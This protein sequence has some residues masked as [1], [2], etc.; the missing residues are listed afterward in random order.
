MGCWGSAME[1]R[2][3][4]TELL[5]TATQQE[6]RVRA[7]LARHATTRHGARNDSSR[8]ATPL[9]LNRVPMSVH[10][11][12]RGYYLQYPPTVLVPHAFLPEELQIPDA[13]RRLAMASATLTRATG[14][15][16]LRRRCSWSDKICSGMA[17]LHE[18]VT[19]N[20]PRFYYYVGGSFVL[21]QILGFG[22]WENLGVCTRPFAERGV[23]E[24][25]RIAAGKNAYPVSVMAVND[26][27]AFIESASLHIASCAILCCWLPDGTRGYELYLTKNCAV[28][29]KRRAVHSCQ[30]HPALVDAP[31]VRAD[32]LEYIRRDATDMRSLPSFLACVR[33]ERESEKW[34]E[35][36][37]N[38]ASLLCVTQYSDAPYTATMG[39][40]FLELRDGCMCNLT[41][42]F[43]TEPAA[44]CSVP[45]CMPVV[46]YPCTQGPPGWLRHFP[47]SRHWIFDLVR[48]GLV[49]SLVAF[50]GG[51]RVHTTCLVPDWLVDR[52]HLTKAEVEQELQ[53][54]TPVIVRG[55]HRKIVS[56]PCRLSVRLLRSMSL[57]DAGKDTWCFLFDAPWQRRLRGVMFCRETGELTERCGHGLCRDYE[58]HASRVICSDVPIAPSASSDATDSQTP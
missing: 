44:D 35:P 56:F 37:S 36:L 13:D 21:S 52:M 53:R 12:M 54:Q 26:M 32:I 15:A 39:Q 47:A 25:F 57:M 49:V 50:R 40:W 14:P 43:A 23:T 6:R 27:E 31:D 29:Y 3:G 28:A 7:S 24:P 4:D 19:D 2:M 34:N 58:L 17:L 45:A 46:C 38:A 8:R 30:L 16:L 42:S 9:D 41:F 18:L 51:T 55:G 48:M 10:E 33:D 11:V 1:H 22:E 5:L 20:E